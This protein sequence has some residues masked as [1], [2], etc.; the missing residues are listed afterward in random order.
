[1]THSIIQLVLVIAAA[2]A[3]GTATTIEGIRSAAHDHTATDPN[4]VAN[5]LTF[6]AIGTVSFF[7]LAAIVF[8]IA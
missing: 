7:S 1:M 3:V 5:P 8:A 6:M 2:L 4:G